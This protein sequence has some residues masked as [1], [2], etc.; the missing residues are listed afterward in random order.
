MEN[1]ENRTC[2]KHDTS[3][4]YHCKLPTNEVLT[5]KKHLT[6]KPD[7]GAKLAYS[8]RLNALPEGC[9]PTDVKVLRDANLDL[10]IENE[11]LRSA[12]EWALGVNGHFGP[13]PKGKG[14]YWWRTELRNRA[15]LQWDG[16]K[17]VSI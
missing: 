1:C 13:K 4:R 11:K 17:Y 14:N 6:A 3:I 16:E 12:I 8:D 2:G 7:S 10:A 9:T 15:G 5:C